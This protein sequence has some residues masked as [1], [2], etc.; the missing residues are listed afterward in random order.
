[1]SLTF[2]KGQTNVYHTFPAHD[3]V[4]GEDYY[5]FVP[6]TSYEHCGCYQTFI[7]GDT[8]VGTKTYHKLWVSGTSYYPYCNISYPYCDGSNPYTFNNY[9]GA[10]RE[11]SLNKKIYYLPPDSTSDT[12]LYNFNLNL[13][14]TLP[15]TYCNASYPYNYISKVDSILIGTKFH[16]CFG[17]TDR[18]FKTDSIY[19]YLIEGIGSTWGLISYLHGQGEYPSG[20]HLNCFSLNGITLY[21]DTNTV[22]QLSGINKNEYFENTVKISP[23][24]FSQSARIA[25]SQSYND[26][27]I[28][29]FNLQGQLVA[30]NLYKNSSGIVFERNGL[31]E[32]MYFIKLTLDGKKVETRKVV[33]SD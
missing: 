24:P 18:F 17:V 2:V 33:I 31:S 6:L 5:D 26:I 20:S 22:C 28:E 27:S 7:T 19:A 29:V 21:P 32:G 10:Y 1:M 13:G 3:A 8:I 25:L 9:D 12:L 15:P 16:K 4:W 30:Q 23:N 14:D 11:D